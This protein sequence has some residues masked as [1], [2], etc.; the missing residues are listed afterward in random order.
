M[1]VG[2]DVGFGTLPQ[3]TLVPLTKNTDGEEPLGL[4][5]F[6]TSY[7]GFLKAQHVLVDESMR[8]GWQMVP[9]GRIWLVSLAPDLGRRP[10]T[11]RLVVEQPLKGN[12][13]NAGNPP[14]HGGVSRG[15]PALPFADGINTDAYRPSKVTLEPWTA[16][17]SPL[18][19]A[20]ESHSLPKASR[21][22][23]F[24]YRHYFLLTG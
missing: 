11:D 1:D 6:G 19:L 22:H 12:A 24:P 17:T 15:A 7:A 3:I 14:R 18:P 4:V 9:E 5:E 8:L 13:Q 16:V 2:D 20:G 23:F 10:L 21:G